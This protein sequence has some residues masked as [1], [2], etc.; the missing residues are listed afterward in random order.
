MSFL[1]KWSYYGWSLLEM[2]F[3]FRDWGKAARLFLRKT[4]QEPVFCV[5]AGKM[6]AYWCAAGWMP[7]L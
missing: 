6:P 3:G 5:C 4:G 1:R 2:A 7:G